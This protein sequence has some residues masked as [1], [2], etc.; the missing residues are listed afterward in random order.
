M[1]AC[2]SHDHLQRRGFLRIGALAGMGLNLPEYLALAAVRAVNPNAKAKAAI[3]IRLAGGPSHMDTFDLKP[4]APDTHRGEFNEIPTCVPGV[5]ICEHLPKL[6]KC[7]DK[8]VI[9]RGVSHNLAAHE[10]GLQYLSTGNRPTPA[11]RYP[12]FG[13]VVSKEFG[14]AADL[15]SF[16]AMPSEGPQP[17]GYL[18]VEHGPF[19]T[20]AMPQP[21]RA[22]EIRGLSLKNGVTLADVDRRQDMLSRYDTAF[23]AFSKED[24]LL[25]G[26]DEFSRK[27]WSMMRSERVRDAFDP[28][29]ESTALAD[30]FGKD[31][32]SQSCLLAPRLIEAGVR[33]VTINLDGWDTHT[34]NFT[35]LKNK[36]LPA[37]DDGLSGLL[38][39]LEEKGLLATTTVFV[40]GE[41]GRTPKIND[42]GGRDHWPR[43]MFS[44]FAGGGIQGGRVIG[45]SDAKG[46]APA[47]RL[48]TPGDLA[49]TFYQ[50]LGIDSRKEYHTPTGRPLMIV[51]E[52]TVIRELVA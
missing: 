1:N 25:A 24:K 44:L 13:A 30:L 52:G 11:I 10:L 39:A 21:G 51:K 27:A 47:D 22:L 42:R 34:G 14:A 6:A 36:N 3:F 35:T 29:R 8:Y 48:I 26:M 4:D 33:F 45:A 9:L 2:T 41:F 43:A 17:T 19:E 28:R 38:L 16:V 50:T 40:S 5:R 31:P 49:A 20:G 15:P 12:T 7:A 32:F 46:E 37:L 18:G 23:G